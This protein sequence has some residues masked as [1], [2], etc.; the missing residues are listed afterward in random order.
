MTLKIKSL[1]VGALILQVNFSSFFLTGNGSVAVIAS[2]FLVIFFKKKNVS[3]SSLLLHILLHLE[4]NSIG[5]QDCI[6]F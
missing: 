6:T 5:S 1:V 4:Y 2:L 3:L